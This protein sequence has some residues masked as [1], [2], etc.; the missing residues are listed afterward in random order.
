MNGQVCA[1]RA[2]L[3]I[4][5]EECAG[6]WLALPDLAHHL[7]AREERVRNAAQ[8]L[9]D[10]GLALAAHRDGIAFF[11]MRCE[12]CAPP[13]SQE[14][15]DAALDAALDASI[16]AALAPREP[17]TPARPRLLTHP[18]QECR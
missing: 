10:A 4:R 6:Q 13:D 14:E 15:L 3:L 5:L 8:Q 1:L 18:Q 11:G 17:A 9:V 2:C 7:G 12:G 16:A